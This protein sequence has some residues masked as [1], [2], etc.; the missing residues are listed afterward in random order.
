MII[1]Q[2]IR[3]WPCFNNFG[4]TLFK[5]SALCA[6]MTVAQAE[7]HPP[8]ETL[9]ELKPQEDPLSAINFDHMDKDGTLHIPAFE[10]PMSIALSDESK[11]AVLRTIGAFP[12]F[13]AILNKE[14]PVP[15]HKAPLE[16]LPEIRRCR[17]EAF[18]KTHWYQDAKARYPANYDTQTIGGV[19]TEIY[20]PV[21]GV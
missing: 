4:L 17:A 2:V 12:E 1:S 6:L 8:T 14:C 18:K 21:E 10:L 11:A 5:A 19:F 20:T 9:E 15:L 3:K 16:D 7:N 13:Q